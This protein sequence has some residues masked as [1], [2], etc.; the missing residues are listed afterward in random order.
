[1]PFL[2]MRM[3]AGGGGGDR[4]VNWAHSCD[5][6]SPTEWL[7]PGDL[8]MSSGLSFPARA[9][10][11]VSF[12]LNL[13]AADL[14]GFAIGDDMEAPPLTPPFL[15]AAEEFDFPVLAI[16]REV[17][18]VAVSR[19]VANANAGDEQ[20]RLVRT[21]QLYETLREGV[22]TDRLG[23]PLL[24]ELSRQLDCKLLL[25]D[26]LTALPVLP[27]EEQAPDALCAGL[28]EELRERKG[29]F[30]GVLRLKRDA[31]VAFAVR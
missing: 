8:L 30:P 28:V 26:A 16:P 24:S 7:A 23:A 3:H 29:V 25:L 27:S 17:P 31:E 21:A 19:A 9:E 13:I 11:Q 20:R 6:P 14:S 22:T 15:T 1:M 4:E 2:R 10:N 5:L 18:F 12:L